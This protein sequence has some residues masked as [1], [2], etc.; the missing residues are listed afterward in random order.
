MQ[1]DS[2]RTCRVLSYTQKKGFENIEYLS[3]LPNVLILIMTCIN[4]YL[5]VKWNKTNDAK[6]E[7]YRKEI[8]S[9]KASIWKGMKNE[10]TFC[11]DAL[12]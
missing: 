11:S 9:L 2:W 10:N 12:L 7:E 8:C 6:I 1:F 4:V 5:T 3:L